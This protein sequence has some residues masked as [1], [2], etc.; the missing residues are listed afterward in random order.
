[1]YF[2]AQ[3]SLAPATRR[4]Y[5]VGQRHSHTFCNMHQRRPVPATEMQLA[6]FVTYLADRV[7]VAPVT[8]K[9]YM[10]AVRSLHVEQ[11]FGNPF[12]GTTLPH[13]VFTGVKRVHG[14]GP[15]LIRL[16]ITL[17]VLRRIIYQLQRA[18]WL[19]H[20]DQLMIGAACSLAFFGFMLCG[21][22][23]GLQSGDVVIR[24]EPTKHLVASLRA[25][26]TDP[27]RQ[28]CSVSV[29]SVND[30]NAP[31]CAVR[32]IEAYQRASAPTMA[33]ANHPFFKY[34]N[35]QALSRAHLTSV[36]QRL[37]ER[38]GCPYAAAFK[39]HSFRSG[40]ATTAAEAGV[41]DWLIK[42]MGR[43]ASDAYLTYIKTPQATLLN[44]ASTL[45][46]RA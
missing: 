12:A 7:K 6:E 34:K 46:R 27:F 23:L 22:L 14:T 39:G 19:P 37:L 3:Q 5:A 2:Y 1:M 10:A 31:L 38:D 29:G 40:A 43:W 41:P 21:E 13:R 15:R 20:T 4:L 11:G 35:G 17:A 45:T 36:V 9:T 8:I 16:P 26:K 24:R 32:L 18:S 25:S 44:V 33:G 28:G 42:T 30:S